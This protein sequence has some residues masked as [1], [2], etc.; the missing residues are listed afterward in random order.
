MKTYGRVD[1]QTNDFLFLDLVGSERSASR[2]YRFILGKGAHGN[3][4]RRDWVGPTAG[5]VNTDKRNS[6]SGLYR[7][8]D[9]NLSAKLVP[10]LRLERCRV[11][12]QSIPTAVNLAFLDRSPYSLI[13]VVPQLSLRG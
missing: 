4:R 6:E 11:S 13:Q 5:L 10:T 12:A 7:Q 2:S 9:C 1:V 8:S 3:H